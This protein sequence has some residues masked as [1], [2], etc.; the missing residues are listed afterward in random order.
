MYFKHLRAA[1]PYSY[2]GNQ[3]TLQAQSISPIYKDKVNKA[4]A[5]HKYNFLKLQNN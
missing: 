4:R 2:R 1:Q 3:K 5:L